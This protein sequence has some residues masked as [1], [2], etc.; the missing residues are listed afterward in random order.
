MRMVLVWS[1]PE[2]SKSPVSSI[3]VDEENGISSNVKKNREPQI[4]LLSYHDKF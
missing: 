2:F 3:D 4:D 1:P